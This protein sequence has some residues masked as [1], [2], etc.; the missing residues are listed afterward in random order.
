M[1]TPTKQNQGHR[2]QTGDWQ[3]EGEGEVGSEVWDSQDE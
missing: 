1:N 3:G 2:E